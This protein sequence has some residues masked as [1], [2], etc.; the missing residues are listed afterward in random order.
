[1]QTFLYGLVQTGHLPVTLPPS[2]QQPLSVT[3]TIQG[4]AS[5][6]FFH[7]KAVVVKTKPAVQPLAP[8]V[9]PLPVAPVLKKD[10]MMSVDVS[11]SLSPM[12]P[13]QSLFFER[14]RAGC[15]Q[16]E[17]IELARPMDL[18]I[19]LCIVEGI[20]RDIARRI[21]RSVQGLL[22]QSTVRAA[23]VPSHSLSIIG[24]SK[25]FA[26]VDMEGDGALIDL[27]RRVRDIVFQVSGL[28][29]HFP[30]APHVS[31]ARSKAPE[32]FRH[33]FVEKTPP[34][35]PEFIF[36]QE[37]L[38]VNMRTVTMTRLARRGENLEPGAA[39]APSFEDDMALSK[40][41]CQ[42]VDSLVPFATMQQQTGGIV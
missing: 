15:I 13:E 10:R 30:F 29:D 23:P 27:C 3:M 6:H 39:A 17:N 32:G 26:V 33:D 22:G 37:H 34:H 12:S 1:M 31:V 41:P 42:G 9:A 24:R 36:G 25:N 4:S 20:S 11:L 18:H 14:L 2:I 8:L 19:S 40:S 38:V 28:Q 35:P 5:A 7:K 21:E 16:C